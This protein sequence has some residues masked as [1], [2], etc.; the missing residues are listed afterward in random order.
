[1]AIETKTYNNDNWFRKLFL[2]EAKAAIDSQDDTTP[3]FDGEITIEKA[4]TE[5]V[6]V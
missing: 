6:S 5:G 4:N 3:Y 2:N 1:M